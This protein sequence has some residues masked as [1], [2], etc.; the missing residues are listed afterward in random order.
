[1]KDILLIARDLDALE[2]EVK[3]RD[4]KIAA[5]QSCMLDG[6][7]EAVIDAALA[8]H[9]WWKKDVYGFPPKPNRSMAP[10][11]VADLATVITRFRA[12]H[13]GLGKTPM[14]IRVK[15]AH[16]GQDIKRDENGNPPRWRHARGEAIACALIATPDDEPF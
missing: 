14:P 16:C 2:A 12:A 11:A 9:D 4:E 5:L 13:P 8:W 10:P 1:M 3:E 7:S 6:P 15:C